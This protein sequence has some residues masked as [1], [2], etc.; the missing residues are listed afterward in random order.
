MQS[1]FSAKPLK[2]LALI[3]IWFFTVQNLF[4]QTPPP[5]PNM[6]SISL[7]PFTDTVVLNWTPI[8]SSLVDG[9]IIND[10]RT[11]N[12]DDSIL[13]VSDPT[14]KTVKFPYPKIRQRAVV[15]FVG[16]YCSL[17]FVAIPRARLLL[18]HL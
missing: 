5:Y 11:N 16:E 7:I 8:V 10:R 17:P 13:Y 12:R 18:L 15:F 3:L 9:Y 6:L 4:C 2:K 14:A 1:H